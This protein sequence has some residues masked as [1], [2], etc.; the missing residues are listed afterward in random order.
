[1]AFF[2][3]PN[4]SDEQFKQLSGTTLTLSGQTNI[5]NPSGLTITGDGGLKIPIILT[6][7]TDNKVLTYL[8]GRMILIDSSD[9]GSTTYIG[10][11]PTTCT[12]GGLTTGSDIYGCSV[13][14][15]LQD[16][17][18]PTAYPTLTNPSSLFTSTDNNTYAEVGDIISVDT[19]S[20]FNRGLITPNYGTSGFR[21]G[22][23]VLYEYNVW[24][25]T[26]T[27]NNTNLTDNRTFGSHEV[28]LGV[29]TISNRVCYGIG[30]QPLDSDGENYCAP[31]PSSTTNF[32]SISLC[33]IYPYFYGVTPSGGVAAGNNRPT[34]TK[35]TITGGTKVVLSS[36]NTIPIN[37]NSTS[38]DY[39]WLAIPSTSTDKT[40]WYI[41]D[42]NSGNI[43][44]AV[45]VGGNL[46]PD[47]CLVT[48]VSSLYWA[49][50]TYKVYLSNYQTQINTDMQIKNN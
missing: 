9:S 28:T 13:T 4:L 35:D 36:D 46:F 45:S 30:E 24:G 6:G 34:I 3:R 37:F 7:G 12:V 41:N 39:V 25:N 44:G 33:G 16:I 17:L 38:D 1:M 47:S 50:L 22:L 49:G 42:F 23:P 43:G 15:I 20:T 18:V 26:T 19:V 10:K 48:N 31:L 8:N 2:S 29:N 11:S 27:F 21:S 40:K 14:C 32:N 5:I